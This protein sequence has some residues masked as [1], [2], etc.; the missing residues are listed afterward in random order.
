MQEP[1][2]TANS[3]LKCLDHMK[4]NKKTKT[5]EITL[6]WKVDIIKKIKDSGIYYHTKNCFA[7]GR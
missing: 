4:K 3:Y 5:I 7:Q 2:K 6:V 1:D